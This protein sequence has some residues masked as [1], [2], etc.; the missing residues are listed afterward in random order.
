MGRAQQVRPTAFAGI[1]LLFLAL[2]TGCSTC[3]D[4]F[5]PYRDGEPPQ[6]HVTTVLGWWEKNLYGAHDTLHGGQPVPGYAG[7]VY[8]ED[9][10][11]QLDVAGN[12][13]LIVYCYD[14]GMPPEPGK[15]P[16]PVESWDFDPHTLKGLLRKDPIGYGYSLFL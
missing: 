11:R 8:L 15:L 13:K 9:G 10:Q 5:D 4:W 14:D 3:K 16:A 2:S 1:G 7:R 6:G 12:G